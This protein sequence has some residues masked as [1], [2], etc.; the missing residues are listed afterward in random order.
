MTGIPDELLSPKQVAAELGISYSK[1][2]QLIADRVLPHYK[3][4]DDPRAGYRI[5]RADLDAYK[6]SLRPKA[7]PEDVA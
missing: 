6:D 4:G 3:L 1:I 2:R 5:G 7:E